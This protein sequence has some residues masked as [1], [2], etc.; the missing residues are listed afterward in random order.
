MGLFFHNL[1]SKSNMSLIFHVPAHARHKLRRAV[2]VDLRRDERSRRRG[3]SNAING[4]A[5]ETIL[6][7]ARVCRPGRPRLLSSGFDQGGELET[8]AE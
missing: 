2:L 4:R 1:I 8:I 3:D 7:G 5:S 6:G